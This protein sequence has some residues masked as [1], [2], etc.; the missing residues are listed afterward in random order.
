[1]KEQI[2]TPSEVE[3]IAIEAFAKVRGDEPVFG[4]GRAP[5]G[6]IGGNL[7]I[8]PES[9]QANEWGTR[10]TVQ[11]LVYEKRADGT[12]IVRD[13]KEQEVA[14]VPPEADDALLP[15]YFEGIAL[16]LRR[17]M[18][19][20]ANDVETWMPWDLVPQGVFK[21]PKNV[22]AEDFAKF[23]GASSASSPETLPAPDDL[24]GTEPIAVNEA[25][26][27]AIREEPDRIENHLVYAD[28]LTEHGDP[29]GE[30]IS[31]SRPDASPMA[32]RRAAQIL[33]QNER[34][35]AGNLRTAIDDS[36]MSGVSVKFALGWM[37]EAWVGL[38]YDLFQKEPK[39]VAKA[40]AGIFGH[41][42]SK[43]LQKITVGCFDFGGGND[44]G[45]LM[46]AFVPRVTLRSLFLGDT[47]SE[48]Q[49]ISWTQ[50]TRLA[51]L[52]S[53]YPRLEELRIHAGAIDVSG[54]ALMPSLKSL[55]LESGGLAKEN[56]VAVAQ[57][58]LVN[59]E[60]L[61]VWTG[62]DSYGGDATMNELRPFLEGECIPKVTR[63]GL[64]NCSFA[65]EVSVE[66]AR[67]IIASRVVELDLSMGCLSN[68]GIDALCAAGTTTFPAL[69]KL[70][71]SESFVSEDALLRLQETFAGVVVEGYRQRGYG[72]DEDDR[73]VLVSE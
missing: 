46:S 26:E 8:L 10:F 40:L 24:T 48:Q 60:H 70:D 51:T 38:E 52:G 20:R 62:S 9:A 45:E 31:L 17:L 56:L 4:W 68:E 25:L 47:N 41:P 32:A 44:Y 49:E 36:G 71:V 18:A 57:A 63:L 42:S 3:A 65:D 27:R 72:G 30:L 73:Y 1:M 7:V 5:S 54:G 67:S 50:A 23:V 34:Y 11:L 28:W 33:A 19:E 61:E 12:A 58:G 64:R 43:F 35:F 13:I 2:L 16:G 22:T 39:F 53:L 69:R 15:A 14:F 66:L 55:R 21:D 59:L 29:R 37:S 6:E